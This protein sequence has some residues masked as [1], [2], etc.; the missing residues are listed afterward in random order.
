MKALLKQILTSKKA[1]AA[2]VACLVWCLGRFGWD[3]PAA[4]LLPVIGIL[5][6]FIA[7][8]ALAD[9]GKEKAKIEV[10]HPEWSDEAKAE[11]DHT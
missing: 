8:Q 7:G 4:E 1:W 2:I 11:G 5:C 3:V 6:T 10:P 9:V